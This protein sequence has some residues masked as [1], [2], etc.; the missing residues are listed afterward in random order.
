[1]K[2]DQ[3][4]QLIG[5][6]DYHIEPSAVAEAILRRLAQERALLAAGAEGAQSECS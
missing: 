2:I 6:G 3:L 1:M 5:S 4:Q